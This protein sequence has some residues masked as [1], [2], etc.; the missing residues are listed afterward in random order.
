MDVKKILQVLMCVG[1][2][3]TGSAQLLADITSSPYPEAMTCTPSA[4][5]ALG[6]AANPATLPFLQGVCAGFYMENRFMVSGLHVAEATLGFARRGSGMGMAA[7]YFGNPAYNEW[8][9]SL[10]YAKQLGDIHLAASFQYNRYSITGYA[11]AQHWHIGLHSLWKLSD[12]VFSTIQLIDPPFARLAGDPGAFAAAYHLGLCYEAGE[13][14]CLSA[15][16]KK[17]EGL[18]LQMVAMVQYRFDRR[19]A[20]RAGL[21][22]AGPQ[23][24]FGLGRQ[25]KDFRFEFALTYHTVLGLSPGCLIDY[26]RPV[27]PFAS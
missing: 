12:K 7:R 9:A 11:R 27:N 18:P 20:L 24:F 4:P 21:S 6:F 5:N 10:Y 14:L 19:Y 1:T 26:Q 25:W 23:P 16:L 13:E 8:H 22:T 2:W 3:C 15:A 17:T